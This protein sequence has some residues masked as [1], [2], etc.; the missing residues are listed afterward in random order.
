MRNIREMLRLYAVTDRMWTGEKTLYEQVEAA[1]KGGVTCV[2]MREKNMDFDEML[3]EAKEL[4]WLCDRYGVPLIVNDSVEIALHSGAHGVHVGQDDM[5]AR[6]VR[7][8]AGDQLIVGVTAK[9]IE[10][11][12]KAQADGA[13]YLGSG[14]IFGTAT[15]VTRSMTREELQAIVHSVSI[16]VVAIGG[17]NRKNLPLLQGTGV[18][19][20]AIVSGIFAAEDI[21]NECRGLKKLADMMAERA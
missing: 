3:E 4:R 16:P 18:A 5:A 7:K 13:D 17:I 11:A 1:L 15:K 21:E 20:A 10:A 6:E 12:Q 2:Q 8:I 9:T 19:G 14:A